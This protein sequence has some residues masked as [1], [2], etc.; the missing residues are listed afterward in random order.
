MQGY[1]KTR[2]IQRSF[3][4]HKIL[5]VCRLFA[6]G[7]SPKFTLQAYSRICPNLIQHLYIFLFDRNNDGKHEKPSYDYDY[8]TENSL[9]MKSRILIQTFQRLISF[10]F[11]SRK[12]FQ[13][14]AIPR[15]NFPTLEEASLHASSH[16]R[17]LDYYN[18]QEASIWTRLAS[19]VFFPCITFAGC[20][21]E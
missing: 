2:Y 18:H 13:R 15:R 7:V 17:F 11:R 3:S 12:G 1:N 10:S 19:Y 16:L 5:Q 8:E 9:S 21:F 14:R 20:V 6:C 4:H